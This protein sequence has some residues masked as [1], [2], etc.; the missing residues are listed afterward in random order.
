MVKYWLSWTLTGRNDSVF[1]LCNVTRQVQNSGAMIREF[2]PSLSFIQGGLW[3]RSLCVICTQRRT[4]DFKGAFLTSNGGY[5]LLFHRR[6]V[7]EPRD[8]TNQATR[9]AAKIEWKS[10]IIREAVKTRQWSAVKQWSPGE[11]ATRSELRRWKGRRVHEGIRGSFLS[12][13]VHF[14]FFPS[15]CTI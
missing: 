6:S 12:L 2:E 10:G 4:T 15:P 1:V 7:K 8:L 14:F 3:T 13:W 9:L 5:E 11:N